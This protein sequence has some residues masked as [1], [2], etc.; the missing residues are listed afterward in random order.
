MIGET[1]QLSTLFPP[2][3]INQLLDM[4]AEPRN[5]VITTHRNPDG[6]ASDSGGESPSYGVG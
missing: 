3:D 5:I 4:L 6:D 1:R 2:A